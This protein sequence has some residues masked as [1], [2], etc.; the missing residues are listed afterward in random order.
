MRSSHSPS[1]IAA[2]RCAAASVATLAALLWSL[3][4]PTPQAFGQGTAE[5]LDRVRDRQSRLA[6][7]LRSQNSAVDQLIGQVSA[8]RAAEQEV[9]AELAER[10]AELDRTEKELK[11]GRTRLAELRQ[12]LADA[13]E[14]LEEML[15]SIYRSGSPDLA[16]LLLESSDLE[17]FGTRNEYLE[18]LESY[19]SSVVDRA[20]SLGEQ[21]EGLVAKLAAD[22]ERVAAA[23]DKIAGRRDEL[24][25]NRAELETQE[26]SLTAARKERRQALASL[27]DREQRLV[28]E[29]TAP[30]EPAAVAGPTAPTEPTPAPAPGQGAKLDSS[31]NAI[32]PAGAPAAVVAAIEAANEISDRPYLWG[33]GHGSFDASGYDCSGAVSYAL[34]GAGL[35]SSPLDSTG[36]TFWGSSGAGRWITV[37]AHSGHAYAVIAGLRWD[38]SGG[39]GPRWHADAR[40]PAGF[41]A[42]HPSGL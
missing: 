36:F 33:G 34:N 37:N 24:A 2:L 19:Q 21:A 42:R 6:E 38:T 27:G 1:R 4:G 40:S 41:V 30:A 17:D 3:T 26:A 11:S 7:Q 22:Q 5:Q 10:Q 14:E 23:R 39:A 16:A 13:S 15:V 25:A 9:V 20:R 29:L 12:E 8:A 28:Q 32:A 18:R 35:L 31:G